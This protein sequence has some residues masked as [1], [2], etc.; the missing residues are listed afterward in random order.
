MLKL[1]YF[2]ADVFTSN[3]FGGNQLAVLPFADSIPEE[4]FQRI[5]REFNF[6]ETA[7]I[8]K[9]DNQKHDYRM[10]IFTPF[11]EIPTAGHPTIGTA[12]ILLNAVKCKTK[13]ENMLLF[14]QKIGDIPVSFSKNNNLCSDITM[15]QP[16]PEFGKIYDN[17]EIIAEILS[18][19]PDD[20]D[21]SIPTEAISCGNKFLY[22]PIKTIEALKNIKM[23]TD[24]L[25]KHANSFETTELYTFT[26]ETEQQESTVHARMFAPLVGIYEDPATGSA[27]GPLGCYLVKNKLND[28]KNIVCE[29]GF[30]MGRPSIVNV[31]IEHLN[32]DIMKVKVGGNSVLVSKGELIINS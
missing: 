4:Y 9:P 13:T 1:E 24:L 19:S 15:T 11:N 26:F 31:S 10:R 6:S 5:A 21:T 30:E 17:Y 8:F 18:L 25:S 28:G 23:R 20:I 7:F 22:I 14:E 16:L 32:G 12:H 2:I 3:I 29:Q 27:S